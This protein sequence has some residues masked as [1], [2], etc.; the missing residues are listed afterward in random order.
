MILTDGALG[1]MMEKVA[2]PAEGS[3]AYPEK[4]WATT[5]KTPDRKANVITSLFIE[6]EHME[7]INLGLQAKYQRMREE[8]VR[9]EEYQIEGAEIILIAYGLSSRICQKAVDLAREAGIK[10]GLL[11]PITLFPFPEKRIAELA[12]TVGAFLD[13]EMNSGQMIEDVR[14]AVNGK[15]EVYFTGRMGG[16][17]PSPEDILAEIENISAHLNKQKAE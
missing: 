10:A 12:K 3:L 14:L 7:Q 15:R 5:G 17:I 2:L 9:F 16:I 4:P 11:R 13:V 8:E 1:Q 6:P